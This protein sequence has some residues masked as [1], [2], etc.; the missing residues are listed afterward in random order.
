[1]LE[2][3]IALVPTRQRIVI[4]YDDF[5]ADTRWEYLRA[6]ALLGLADDGRSDFAPVND[7]VAE[8]WSGMADFQQRLRRRAIY[9]PAAA[10]AHASRIQALLDP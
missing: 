7:N 4:V 6:L 10:V 3:F 8:R 5:R 2:R 9:K 1:M